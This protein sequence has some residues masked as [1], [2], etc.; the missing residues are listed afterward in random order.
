MN[1]NPSKRYKEAANVV[2]VVGKKSFGA[3]Q[4]A[5]N[6]EA[7]LGALAKSQPAGFVGTRFVKSVT[8]SST[9]SPGISLD[10]RAV[11]V[12]PTA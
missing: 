1:K 10:L 9:M 2:I 3:Q 7:A 4:L 12:A 8:L 6:I 11:T 5:Q